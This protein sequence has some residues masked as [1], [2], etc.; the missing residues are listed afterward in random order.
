VQVKTYIWH[1][2]MFRG[3]SKNAYFIIEYLFLQYNETWLIDLLMNNQ[4]RRNRKSDKARD[5]KYV[6]C[7]TLTE[8][9][10]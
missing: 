8:N 4:L 5:C 3:C 10:I 2:G 1:E 9:S 6:L 7:G